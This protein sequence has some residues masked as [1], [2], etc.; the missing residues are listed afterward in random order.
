MKPRFIGITQGDP[1][2]IGPEVVLKSL[3][4]FLP[5]Q[6]RGCYFL[7]I[8]HLAVFQ[9]AAEMLALKVPFKNHGSFDP[10]QF[11]P[12]AI[13]LLEPGPIRP[14]RLGARDPE[15]GRLAFDCIRLGA[16]LAD[17]GCLAGLMTAPVSKEAIKLVKA[18]FVGHTEYLAHVSGVKTVAMMLQGGPLRVIPVTTHVPLKQVPRLLTEGKIIE[19][20][21]L[22][23]RFL[24]TRLRRDP[25]IGVAALNP[26]AGEGGMM[27]TE[28]RR[29]IAPAVRKLCR[30]GIR[31]QG[32]VSADTIFRRAYLG[33]LDAV[34]AMYH[35]QGLGPFKMIA[36]EDGINVTLGLPYRRSSS[37]HGTAFDIAYRGVASSA[38]SEKALEFL[39]LP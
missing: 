10:R 22:V 20:T 4:K 35:D 11:D 16:Y 6:R 17:A 33:K 8:G 24:R 21:R 28:E 27:G 7:I 15:N 36:F 25:R 38:S 30:A 23:H 19:Q 9:R 37:D 31:A 29:I 3:I 5:L 14:Y 13:N 12:R 18:D 34:M 32:P 26:H 2:G 1:G 39:I